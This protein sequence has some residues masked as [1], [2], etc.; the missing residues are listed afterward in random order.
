[1]RQKV[2]T[3]I[4]LWASI[5]FSMWMLNGR[6][7]LSL[8][9]AAIA[10]GVTI[11]LVMIK[12]YRPESEP[13][14]E[15]TELP[16]AESLSLSKSTTAV[17]PIGDTAVV[18]RQSGNPAQSSIGRGCADPLVGQYHGSRVF[19]PVALASCAPRVIIVTRDI[20]VVAA[21]S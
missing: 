16:S 2:S 3:I 13:V 1:M 9:M 12:T 5:G 14:A 7:W 8:L 17:S 4:T 19:D 20:A 6:F 21:A 15:S 10:I 11:H 18:F